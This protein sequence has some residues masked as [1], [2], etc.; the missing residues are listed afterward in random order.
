MDVI[1]QGDADFRPTGAVVAPDG[2]VYFADWVSRSYPV[3]GQGRIWRLKVPAEEREFVGVDDDGARPWSDW[4]FENDIRQAEIFADNQV[5][6][7]AWDTAVD[8]AVRMA[9]LQRARW[10]TKPDVMPQLRSALGDADPNVRLYAVRWI[11]DERLTALR[12]DVAK[13]L[14]G[15]IP[16]E[17]YFLAV[18]AAIEW[19]DGDA[20]PR[21]SG[22]S[23]GLLRR[24][25]ANR[26]RSPQIKTLALRLISP[27]HP[28]LT[29]DRVREYLA[30]DAPALRLEAVRTL[31]NQTRPERLPLLAE[32]AADATRDAELRA[33]AVVGLTAVAGEHA[34]LL[35][36]LA[37]ADDA[38]LAKEAAR[39][40]RL[41]GKPAATATAPQHPAA[42]DLDAWTA[43]LAEGGDAASGR[44]L[45][46]TNQTLCATCHQHGGRGGRVGPDLTRLGEQQSR[47]RI[48]ASILQPS[49][50]I[51]PHYQAWELVTTDGLSRRGL[52]LP[53]GGDDGNEPYADPD[54]RTFTLKSEDI[55]LR[56]PSD[57]SIMPEGLADKLTIDDLRDLTAFLSQ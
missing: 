55:E 56:T 15:D 10:H 6:G 53:K 39:V 35:E 11:A 36:Q 47:D 23:D 8:P 54:G 30:S 22:I 4:G 14:D 28:W 26:D 9:A 45:F 2:S 16:T 12:D 17:R 42:T 50:E 52:R 24:E 38:L 13:L 33:E 49:R 29:L 20:A 44:R 31:A 32:I 21:S 7:A 37:A 57:V 48:I 46:F 18:L 43:L 1:V 34:A 5:G 41:N 3:H 51:A 25:L 19:L 27:D 40:L